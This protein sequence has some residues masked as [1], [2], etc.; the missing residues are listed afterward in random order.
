MVFQKF[1]LLALMTLA[2]PALADDAKKRTCAAAD[3]ACLLSDLQSLTPTIDDKNWR[4]QTNREL[5]KML[6]HAHRENEAI[7]LI[8][9]IENPDTKA[10]TIR[11]IGMAAASQKWAKPEY[12]ALFSKLAAEAEKITHPPSYGIALTY[13]AM[14]QAFAGDDSGAVATAQR[15]ENSDLRKKAFGETAEIQAERNDLSAV[16]ATL[17]HIEDT[18]YRDKELFL[19]AKLFADRKQFDSAVTL[20]N[21]ITAP[22]HRANALL[23]TIGKQI[24]PD[25]VLSGE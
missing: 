7:A 14:A 13:I 15:M 20:G 22:Y 21:S 3:T 18:V 16:Q 8:E 5:A 19:I 25:E 4:D 11:G 2:F 9:K 24:A 23:Y 17:A 10:M 1:L 12:D 6:T